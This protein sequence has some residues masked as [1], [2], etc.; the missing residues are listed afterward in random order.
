MPFR[1]FLLFNAAGGLSWGVAVVIAGYMAGA[2]DTTIETWLGRGT[3]IAVAVIVIGAVII[4]RL[5]K[6][7]SATS[8]H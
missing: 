6:R 7:R 4:W 5:R 1:R 2:S 8:G 3:G